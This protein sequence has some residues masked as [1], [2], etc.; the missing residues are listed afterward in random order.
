[1]LSVCVC[2]LLLLRGL[3]VR[4]LSGVGLVLRMPAGSLVVVSGFGNGHSLMFSQKQE[5]LHCPSHDHLDKC[6]RL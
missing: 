2:V 1:M 4:A 5:H 6:Y 3:L